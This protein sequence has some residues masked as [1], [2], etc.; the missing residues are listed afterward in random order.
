MRT[1]NVIGASVC[2]LLFAVFLWLKIPIWFLFLFGTLYYT[3]QALFR[4]TGMTRTLL[5]GGSV[6]LGVLGVYPMRDDSS[7]QAYG[8]YIELRGVPVFVSL[9]EDKLVEE[10]R[11]RALALNENRTTL[12]KNLDRFVADRPG[13]RERRVRYIGLHAPDLER[14]EVFWDPDGHTSL[15]GFSFVD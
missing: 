7:D 3:Y 1:K 2:A 15:Q 5:T 12:E 6:P 10:R 14:G 13:F 11:R 4:R 8:M 9:R